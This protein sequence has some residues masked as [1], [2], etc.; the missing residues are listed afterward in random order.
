MRRDDDVFCGDWLADD[1][2]AVDSHRHDA[3]CSAEPVAT[4][5]G[6]STLDND[7]KNG[8][9]SRRWKYGAGGD[10]PVAQ[11]ASNTKP[12]LPLESRRICRRRRR[13]PA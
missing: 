3:S 4:A 8:G 11:A 7:N 10:E 2:I 9:W 13:R 6:A 1:Q 12:E 5:W